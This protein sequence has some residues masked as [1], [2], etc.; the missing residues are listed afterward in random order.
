MKCTYIKT[1][2]S[3]CKANALRGTPYCWYHSPDISGEEKKLASSNGGSA[4][5]CEVFAPL[6]PLSIS[7]MQDVPAF[8]IDTI[9]NLRNG[10]ISVR[11][12]TALGYLSHMLM[13]S[14]EIADLEK[15]IETMEGFLNVNGLD[16]KPEPFKVDFGKD[17]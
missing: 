1:D 15:R 14:F 13:Q 11:L 4:N 6:A 3:K 9:Q 17:Y 12:A 10:I 5:T 16:Y 7:K 8:L 2:G